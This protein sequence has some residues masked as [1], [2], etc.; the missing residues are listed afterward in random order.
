MF[1]P[2]ASIDLYKCRRPTR[3]N[4]KRQVWQLR[5]FGTDG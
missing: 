5:W 4:P 2:K 1:R 3:S